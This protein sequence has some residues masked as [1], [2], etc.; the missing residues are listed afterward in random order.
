ML[1]KKLSKTLFFL[2]AFFLSAHSHA[3]YMRVTLL[4]TGS[5]EPT[6]D[7]FGP[8]VLVEAGGIYLLFDAGRGVV[9]RL[10]QLEV[11]LSEVN[12]LFLTHLHSD[13]VID[14]NDVWQTG[15]MWQRATPL[16][17]YGPQG[18]QV[19]TDHIEKAL[20]YDITIRHQHS[21]LPLESAKFKTTEIKEGVVFKQDNIVVTAFLVDHGVVKPAFGY[22]VDFMGRSVVISG[23]TTYSQN[24][25]SHAK[26]AD[27]LIHEVAAAPAT[28]KKKN[29]NVKKI[30]SYHS[31]PEQV[32]KVLAAVK[33]KMAVLTH[34][35][36]Y[37]VSPEQVQADI[38]KNYSGNVVIGEDL[39]QIEI[40]KDVRTKRYT[41][42]PLNTK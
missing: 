15:W 30:L 22:R 40:G 27:V 1:Q 36:L 20:I 2:F 34:F 23:D 41:I 10:Y 3:E 29:P 14:V 16:S 17:V 8:A 18:T 32:A 42:A 28:L 6:I 21:G 39:L 9:Q 26:K 25:I 12:T 19:L 13:H 31:S 11:P 35:V 24:L 7:R 37:G 38:M 4:G 33:P 5:P